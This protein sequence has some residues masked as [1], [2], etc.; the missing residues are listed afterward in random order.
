NSSMR[1]RVFRPPS[2]HQ[3]QAGSSGRKSSRA[4][5]RGGS[6]ATGGSR[7]LTNGIASGAGGSSPSP[8][9]VPGTTVST[10]PGTPSLG[11][12]AAMGRR[13]REKSGTARP[14]TRV[15]P[16]D[17]GKGPTDGTSG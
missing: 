7:D 8:S 6:G 2:N 4:I 1:V 12:D 14:G 16:S 3:T 13:P 10:S 5:T 17:P 15:T 9:R 11:P